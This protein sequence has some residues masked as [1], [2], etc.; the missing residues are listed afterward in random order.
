[1]IESIA[2]PFGCFVAGRYMHRTGQFYW[3]MV[4]NVGVY[5]TGLTILYNWIGGNVAIIGGTV[6][7]I[8]QG[9]G[10]GGA[11]VPLI[12]AVSSTLTNECR[13]LF[14]NVVTTL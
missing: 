10:Y 1:M 9:V 13:F 8:I 11:V 4:F 3:F 12:V 6:G 7:I 2:I 5:V 14:F